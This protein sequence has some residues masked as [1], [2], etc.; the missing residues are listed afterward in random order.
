MHD[1]GARHRCTTRWA[2]DHHLHPFPDARL[3]LTHNAAHKVADRQQQAHGQEEPH[4]RFGSIVCSGVCGTQGIEGTQGHGSESNHEW[5]GDLVA[6][7]HHHSQKPF[8]VYAGVGNGATRTSCGSIAMGLD[9]AATTALPSTDDRSSAA[10]MAWPDTQPGGVML[11]RSSSSSS[12]STT[13]PDVA[14]RHQVQPGQQRCH[15]L[16]H[17][18]RVDACGGGCV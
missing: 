8:S 15:L 16:L 13:H 2:T 4:D 9:S 7:V 11:V 18:Q 10:A 3:L 14:R 12:S 6:A 17:K 1:T 5:V